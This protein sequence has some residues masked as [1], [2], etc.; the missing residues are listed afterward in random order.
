MKITIGNR[1]ALGT[2]SIVEEDIDVRTFEIED[3]IVDGLDDLTCDP[4][5]K[6]FIQSDI[7]GILPQSPSL[8]LHVL[9]GHKFRGSSNN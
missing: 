6:T 9:T 4:F 2:H 3:D 8:R 1:I 5:I 7:H